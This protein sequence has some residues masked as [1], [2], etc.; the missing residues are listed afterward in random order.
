MFDSKDWKN[1]KE[2]LM[3]DKDLLDYYMTLLA[4]IRHQGVMAK[5]DAIFC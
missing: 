1:A 4:K 5:K 2:I 3:E